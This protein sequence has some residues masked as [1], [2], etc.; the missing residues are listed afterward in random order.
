M[1]SKSGEKLLAAQRPR[2]RTAAKPAL[3]LAGLSGCQG[4]RDHPSGLLTSWG[5][6]GRT[7]NLSGLPRNQGVGLSPGDL[8]LL[9]AGGGVWWSLVA[10]S[11]P[12]HLSKLQLFYLD[13]EDNHRT[14]L[15]GS[16]RGLSERICAQR[17]AQ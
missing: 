14:D 4:A 5:V 13:K 12:L 11:K 3:P 6:S 8:A 15:T 9:R 10:W 17:L 2:D 7:H 16:V 1:Y